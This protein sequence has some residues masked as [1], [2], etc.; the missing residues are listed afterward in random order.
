MNTKITKEIVEAVKKYTRKYP[1]MSQKEIAKLCGISQCSVS[2]IMNGLYEYLLEETEAAEDTEK[3]IKS[4][5]PYGTYRR[6]VSCE[7]AIEELIE[8]SKKKINGDGLL[9]IDYHFFSQIIKKYFPESYDAKL[10]ELY[11]ED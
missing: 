10:N 4:E 2:G 9:F 5:I 1:N 3:A 6:L 8:G 11:N 7:L